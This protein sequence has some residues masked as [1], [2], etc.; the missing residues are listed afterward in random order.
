MIQIAK[1]INKDVDFRAADIFEL[2][3]PGLFGGIIGL[4]FIVN[5]RPE[6]L[7]KVFDKLHRLLKKDGRFLLSFHLGQDELVSIKNFWNSG[8]PLDF[9]FFRAET[10]Q[11]KLEDAG[12]RITEIRYR[13]PY[14]DIEYNSERAYVFAEKKRGR[15]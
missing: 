12:L 2:N 14:P 4:Y 1:E 8:K 13:Y 7:R 15:Q 10:V 6:D 3:E 9:Y 11:R 5:F